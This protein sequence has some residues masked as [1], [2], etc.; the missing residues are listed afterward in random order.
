LGLHGRFCFSFSR[1]FFPFFF[2]G[3]FSFY[4]SACFLRLFLSF[5]WRSSNPLREFLRAHK[6]SSIRR[7]GMRRIDAD[8]PVRGCT[9]FHGP[10]D[11]G[12]S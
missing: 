4:R 2:L 6:S 10:W 3:F 7:Q 8:M 1:F 9:G 11:D 5:F 12:V